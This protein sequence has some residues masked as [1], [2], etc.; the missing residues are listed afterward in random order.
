[1]KLGMLLI[2][3]ALVL[4]GCASVNIRTDKLPESM[5]APTF[6]QNY[7]YWWWGLSGEYS[8]N[9]REVCQGK[10]VEQ[11]QAV[12]TFTDSVLAIVTLGIYSR[13]TARVWCKEE[14]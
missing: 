4:S 3:S 12:S 10:P 14:N 11:M 2:I 1:M 6:E 9:V 5:A 7:V 8:V 13:R